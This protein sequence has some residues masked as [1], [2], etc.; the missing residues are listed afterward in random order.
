[1]ILHDIRDLMKLRNANP[2]FGL[3]GECITEVDGSKLI[4]TRKC[5]E[6]TVVLK[7]DLKIHEFT[8]E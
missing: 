8:I 2:A 7:A 3:D 1:M 6:H 4:I 5:N